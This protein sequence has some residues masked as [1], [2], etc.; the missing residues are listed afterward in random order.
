MIDD[1]TDIQFR[2]YAYKLQSQG[3]NMELYLQYTGQTV[4][5]VKG[6]LRV[7]A[8]RQVKTR[9]ALEK[10]AA[11]ENL[12][13]SEEDCEEEYAKLAEAYKMEVEEIKG[14][15]LPEDMK[16]DLAIKKAVDFIK[17]NASIKREEMTAEEFA[18]KHGSRQ[19]LP[20]ADGT[21]GEFELEDDE[22]EE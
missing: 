9:L 3:I 20:E 11:L 10:I 18:A 15:V 8:E 6:A 4:E 13:I 16:K 2:D 14:H 19:D 12:E 1:E 5:Q 22:I 7:N 21:D 17:D